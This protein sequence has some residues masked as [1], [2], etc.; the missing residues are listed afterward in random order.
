MPAA[1]RAKRQAPQHA[2]RCYAHMP[3]FCRSGFS[4]DERRRDRS[5]SGDS[6]D[7]ASSTTRV[8]GSAGLCRQLQLR[9]P[10]LSAKAWRGASDAAPGAGCRSGVD[11]VAGC[12]QGPRCPLRITQKRPGRAVESKG[13]EPLHRRHPAGGEFMRPCRGC[14]LPACASGRQGVRVA[15]KPVSWRFSAATRSQQAASMLVGNA[16][17]AMRPALAFGRRSGLAARAAA[18]GLAHSAR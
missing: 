12:R 11:P 17:H 2:R 3:L 15:L 8:A 13:R 6:R 14:G 18:C 4:R 7:E 9:Q 1:A 10:A 16:L 5:N